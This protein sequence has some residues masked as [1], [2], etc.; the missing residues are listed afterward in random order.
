MDAP[1]AAAPTYSRVDDVSN[2]PATRTCARGT[3]VAR[4]RR[5][6]A[7]ELVWAGQRLGAPWRRRFV[8]PRATTPTHTPDRYCGVRLERDLRVPMRDGVTLSTHVFHPASAAQPL[9]AVLI[10]QP[11]GNDDHPCMHARGRYWARKGYVCVVQDVR[12]KYGSQGVW[13][14]VVGEAA[15]GWDALDW[16]AGRPWCNGDIGMV[17]ES[18]Y[19]LTQWAVA[20][21][22]HP[23]LRCVA[24]GDTAPD[25]YRAVYPG[26]AFA[27]MTWGEW[28]YEMETRT[29]RNPYRF[30]PWHL[31]L[32]DAARAAGADSAT[33]RDFVG[34]P[35]RDAW[36]ERRDLTGGGV[37]VPGLHWS[38][39]YDV[40]LDGSLAGWRAAAEHAAAAGAQSDPGRPAAG[41]QQLVIGPT[42]HG[43]TPMT[44]G[45]VGRI[46]VGRDTWSFDV[47]QRFVDRFLQGTPNGAD[48]DPAVRVFV[49]GA[50]RWRTADSWPLPG[51]RFTRFHLHSR[52]DATAVA[53]GVLSPEAPGDETPDRFVYDPDDPVASWLGR[54]LWDM[55]GELSDRRPLE[56]R[57]DVLVYT[58]PPLAADL[59]VVGPL[60]ATLYASTTAPDTDFTA[61]LVD[62]FPDGHAQFV[63][64]GI[65][66]LAALPGAPEA[67]LADADLVRVLPI[68]MSATG[69][70]FAAGHSVR[71]EVS[72]SNFGRFDRNLNSG[73][74]PGADARRATAGQTVY[75]DARRPSHLTLPVIPAGD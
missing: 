54:S 50:G 30:D 28:A 59:E 61:A 9:P 4:A 72:S 70:L 63:Q 14:P 65:V 68:E 7:G 11:Y 42:D 74:T 32:A 25:L 38:G 20:G 16:V 18:Y 53:G 19:G 40:L 15:D 51:T 48:H 75:H 62:V 46:D 45:H 27:L 64:E 1:P 39:W 44:S 57:R 8:N 26:G 23:N 43:L 35:R 73:H 52:G 31:P 58:T 71:L 5:R 12:G 47:V 37:A 2:H 34:H 24:P 56:G 21:A 33:F 41:V 60:S 55:A 10:R 67:P 22:G 13:E 29:Q 17:G 6:A 49:V 3:S 69:H 36:W 66:R